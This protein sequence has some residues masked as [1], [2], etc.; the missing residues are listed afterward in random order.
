[1][2]VGLRFFPPKMDGCEK[3]FLQ[4][5]LKQDWEEEEVDG[6]EIIP[7]PNML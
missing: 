3:K 7:S 1:M 4:K 2:K 5:F 6:G